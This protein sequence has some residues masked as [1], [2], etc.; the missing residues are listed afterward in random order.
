MQPK[1]PFLPQEFTKKPKQTSKQANKQKNQT[2]TG[3]TICLCQ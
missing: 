2:K 1:I 3:G